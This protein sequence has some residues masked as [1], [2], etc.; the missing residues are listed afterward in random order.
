MSDLDT[1]LA[2]RLLDLAGDVRTPSAV[3]P[4]LPGRA[5][6]KIA[7]NS[8][9]VPLVIASVAGAAGLGLTALQRSQ[10]VPVGPNP[11]S[12]PHPTMTSH[13][14]LEPTE[15]AISPG[16]PQPPQPEKAPAWRVVRQPGFSM[17]VPS[18]WSVPSGIAKLVWPPNLKVAL[19]RGGTSMSVWLQPL[20][21]GVSL[22]DFVDGYRQQLLHQTGGGNPSPVGTL[23]APAGQI[24]TMLIN[25]YSSHHEGVEFL[26]F[27][28]SGSRCYRISFAFGGRPNGK[29]LDL[30]GLRM[31]RIVRSFRPR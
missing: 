26:Y 1:K 27:V 5:R 19:G 20:P 9:V 7:L 28:P 14:T 31:R 13:G 17:E 6:R 24:E 10:P 12:T 11:I 4:G 3:P 23:T 16:T 15:P 2:D 22:R 21:A 29:F 30:V 25:G 8:I 18:D